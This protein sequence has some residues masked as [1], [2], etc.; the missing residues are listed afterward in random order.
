MRRFALLVP[1]VLI[2]AAA[3][4]V[5]SPPPVTY[6]VEVG[7]SGAPVNWTSVVDNGARDGGTVNPTSDRPVRINLALTPGQRATVQVAIEPR[8]GGYARCTPYLGA[9]PLAEPVDQDIAL[10]GITG[11]KPPVTC[12]VVAR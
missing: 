1:A 5:P 8:F 11:P 9:Q 12:E 2:A 4:C 7:T 3:A 6:S 10:P